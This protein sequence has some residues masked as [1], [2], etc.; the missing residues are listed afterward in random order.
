MPAAW[1]FNGAIY[2]LRTPLL[3]D[4]DEP[5]LY[6]D[7]VAAYVMPR[8]YGHNLDDPDDWDFAE[9]MLSSLA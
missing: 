5:T 9:R 7:R 1:V 8:P 6:G 4:T 3:F 2:L